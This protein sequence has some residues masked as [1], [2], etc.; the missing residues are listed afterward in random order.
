[1]N[2]ILFSFFLITLAGAAYPQ[3]Q[4][5]KIQDTNAAAL[6]L[7]RG[8]TTLPVSFDGALNKNNMA[9]VNTPDNKDTL[10]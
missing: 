3:S 1:M 10:P 2:H 7:Q 6:T 4:N 8:M 5:A 9:P